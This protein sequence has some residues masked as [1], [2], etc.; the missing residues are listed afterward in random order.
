M[1]TQPE[2]LRLADALDSV[3]SPGPVSAELRRLHAE[4]KSLK[5]ALFQ[6]QEAAKQLTRD[7]RELASGRLANSTETFGSP[8]DELAAIIV[9]PYDAP[10]LQWLCLHPPIRG[11]RLYLRKSKK[12]QS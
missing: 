3:T 2:A 5:E 10:G 9:D 1:N 6:V 11:D 12:E 8:E 4:N 7:C